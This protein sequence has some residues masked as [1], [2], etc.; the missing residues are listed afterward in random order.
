MWC[1]DL[2]D[3]S[4][5]REVTAFLQQEI[6]GADFNKRRS[7]LT[8]S[9]FLNFSVGNSFVK[10]DHWCNHKKCKSRILLKIYCAN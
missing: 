2:G 6:E 10:A 8:V 5:K 3:R 7:G 4:G 9:R 1:R